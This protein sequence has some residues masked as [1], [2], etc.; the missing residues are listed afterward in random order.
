MGTASAEPRRRGSFMSLNSAV[1]HFSAG[2][3]AFIAGEIL[4]KARDGRLLHYPWVGVLAVAATLLSLALAA[5]LRV[6][7]DGEVHKTVIPPALDDGLGEALG[8]AA[9]LPESA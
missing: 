2:L 9:V 4:V 6:V 8:S 5:R 1:Q 3:G 7:H